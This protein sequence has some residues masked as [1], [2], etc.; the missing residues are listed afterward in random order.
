MRDQL[1]PHMLA[2]QF[3]IKMTDI[4]QRASLDFLIA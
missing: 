2:P 3:L 1:D 4:I